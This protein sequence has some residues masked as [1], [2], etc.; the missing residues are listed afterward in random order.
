MKTENLD[1]DIDNINNCSSE[2]E[3]TLSLIKKAKEENCTAKIEIID[4]GNLNENFKCL[5]CFELFESQVTLLKHYNKV[6]TKKEDNKRSDLDYSIL[7][8]DGT[9]VYKCKKCSKEYSNKKSINRHIV[10]H[11]EN[12]PFICKICGKTYK[13]ASE[14]IR[15]GRVHSGYKLYCP[16]Q[17]GYSTVYLGALR[18]HERR[19]N[20]SEYKYKCEKCDKGFEVKTWYEQHQNVH[21]GLKPFVC[22]LCGVAFHMDRYLTAHR[23][24]VHPQSSKLKRYVC[25]H[26]ALP[27]DSMKTLTEH[28]K[29]HGI[30]SSYL[31]DVCGKTLTNAEQLK[32]H[33]RMHLGEK[34]YSCSTCNKSFAKKFN[35][36]LHQRT[37]TGERA[38]VCARCNKR[39]T[40]RSTLRRHIARYIMLMHAGSES[41]TCGICKEKFA[42][43]NQLSSHRKTCFVDA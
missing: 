33:K 3:I 1:N 14:I 36:Q 39:Y 13:T 43:R 26:C 6:H 25:V 10:G 41:F 42:T 12:R 24:A 4:K 22:N 9:S 40:Q 29:V 8:S 38:F 30:K 19:H 15:H 16:Q 23:S 11:K 37:H 31:C 35:L 27:C 5:M 7:S 17:C 21:S 32:F 2:D 28:L 20:R 18:E 34:P